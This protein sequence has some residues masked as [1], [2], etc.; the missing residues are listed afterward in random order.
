MPLPWGGSPL[1][2][3]CPGFGR[4]PPASP[5]QRKI[6]LRSKCNCI[7]DTH[8]LNSART[9][10]WGLRA[11]ALE[12]LGS[13]FKCSSTMN[14]GTYLLFCNVA[15]FPFV[16]LGYESKMAGQFFK[17]PTVYFCI[18]FWRA[19]AISPQISWKCTHFDLS[20]DTFRVCRW[21][22]ERLLFWIRC[23][24]DGFG[25]K[26]WRL[27]SL[28]WKGPIP[29]VTCYKWFALMPWLLDEVLCHLFCQMSDIIMV[30]Y[31]DLKVY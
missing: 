5:I 25:P 19:A 30:A 12:K 11:W 9:E 10:R 15:F 14:S 21:Q 7:Q 29:Q 23:L 17:A 26:G 1:H 8:H 28:L 27:I 22:T 3:R 2:L 31:S 16:N 4:G 18:I 24:P 13:Q 6:G 20:L